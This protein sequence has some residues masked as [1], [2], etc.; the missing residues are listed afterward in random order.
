MRE[1]LSEIDAEVCD[2]RDLRESHPELY[3]RESYA[4]SQPFEE[5]LRGG[6][7]SGIVYASVRRPSGANLVDKIRQMEPSMSVPWAAVARSRT[8]SFV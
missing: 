5:A 6:G 2:L 8:D 1:L 7:A 3:D 4:A